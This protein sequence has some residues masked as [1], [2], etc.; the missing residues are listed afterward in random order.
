VRLYGNDGGSVALSTAPDNAGACG[1]FVSQAAP[2][3]VAGVPANTYD[4]TLA[5]AVSARCL[6]ITYTSCCLWVNAFELLAYAATTP[7]G[8]QWSV[9]GKLGNAITVS[10]AWP[11]VTVK[12]SASLK[13]GANLALEAWVKPRANVAGT[14]RLVG[15]GAAATQ[16][17]DLLR[18]PDGDL[19]WQIDGAGGSGDC[20]NNLGPTDPLN[21][22]VGK[23]THVAGTFNGVT[24]KVYVNGVMR[25]Q[26]TFVDTPLTSTDDLAIGAGFD[27]SID[28]VAIFNSPLSDAIIAD[29]YLRGM[30][31]DAAGAH[32]VDDTGAL[33]TT[34]GRAAAALSFDAIDDY[35][36][37]PDA[38]DLSFTSTSSVFTLSASIKPS[39]VVGASAIIGKYSTDAGSGSEYY[40][41][42]SGDQLQLF[43][44]ADGVPGGEYYEV[45]TDA[46]LTTGT[47]AD[48]SVVI[49]MQAASVSFYKD[50]VLLNDITVGAFPTA[51][52]DTAQPLMIGGRLCAGGVVCDPF[53]GSIDEV[54]VLDGACV[55]IAG[56]AAGLVVSGVPASVTAGTAASVTVRAVTCTLATVTSYTGTMT[57]SSTDPYPAAFAP[58]SY[59]FTGVDAGSKVFTNGVTLK[60]AGT[61]SVT[62]TDAGLG[63]GGTQA[64]IVVVA[65][66]AANLLVSSGTP[67]SGTV[68]TALGLPLVVRVTDTYGNAIAGRA[69]TWATS[70]GGGGV[71]PSSS[72]TNAS[73]LATADA[74]LGTVSG[75][76]NN[77]WTATSGALTPVS[78]TATANPGAAANLAVSS[79]SPQSGTVGT[80]LGLPLAVRVTD[81]YGNVVPG[82]TVSWTTTAGG[83][84]V[85]P[86]TSNTD[87][88]GIATASATLG[89]VSGTGNNTWTATLGVLTPATFTATANPGAAANL[90]VYSGSPQSGTVGTALGLPLAVR[91]IDSYGNP[92][93][94]LT[95]TWT[96]TLGGGSVAPATSDTNASGI[97]EAGATLGTVS[98]TSNNQWTATRVGLAGSPATFT[99]T[100]TAGAA[101]SIAA[102]LGVGQSG[103]VGTALSQALAVIVKDTYGNAV[104]GVL[105]GWATAAGGGGI[106]PASST[107]SAGGV[108]TASATLGT[109][110]GTNNNQWTATKTGLAGSPVTFT[111]TANA[112]AAVA[113]ALGGIGGA[114]VAGALHTVTVTALDQFGNTAAGYLGTVQWSS[115][116]GAAVLPFDLTFGG[117][118]FGV[119]VFTDAVVLKTAATQSVTVTDTVNGLLT[120]SILGIL[121]S[122]EAASKLSVTGITA[123]TAGVA[124]TV[125]VT[126]R[127]PF[128]NV[129]KGYLGTVAFGSDDP[130]PAS[131]PGNTTF[132]ALDQGTRTFTNGVTFKTSGT[133]T[134]TATDVP[135]SSITGLQSG[136]VVSPAARDHV[137]ISGIASPQVG[138]NV[139]YGLQVVDSFGNITP[140]VTTLLADI[141]TTNSALIA[142]TTLLGGSTGGTSTTGSTDGQG[143][144]QVT[145]RDDVTE[146]V[147]LCV[148]SPSFVAV[149]C[150]PLTFIPRAADHLL[151]T[152]AVTSLVVGTS[153]TVAVQLVD[154]FDNGVAQAVAATLAVSGSARFGG[155][156]NT[157]SIT[158]AAGTGQTSTQVT[159]TV[160]GSVSVSVTSTDKGGGVPLAGVS[161]AAGIVFTAAAVHHAVLTTVP[162]TTAGASF[163]VNIHA[164]DQYGNSTVGESE[165][166]LTTNA[167]SGGSPLVVATAGTW[168]APAGSMICGKT[169]ASDGVGTLSITDT[170]AE[171]IGLV[172]TSWVGS[173]TPVSQSA[174]VAVVPAAADHLV[175]APTDG[176]APTCGTELVGMQL[177]DVYGNAVASP[178]FVG[179]AVTAN[180]AALHPKVAATSVNAAVNVVS[181]SGSLSPGGAGDATVTLDGVDT[182]TL[183]WTLPGL[184]GPPTGTVAVVFDTGAP[185]AAKSLFV[186]SPPS[187]AKIDAWSGEATLTVTPKDACGANLGPGYDVDLTATFGLLSDA[188]PAGDGK[189]RALDNGDGTYTSTFRTDG[190][191]CPAVPATLSVVV[192][193]PATMVPVALQTTVSLSSACEPVSPASVVTPATASLEACAAGL[194]HA[195]GITHDAGAFTTVS[196]TPV[197]L[198]GK[199][200]GPN[201]SVHINADGVLL[202]EQGVTSRIDP[203]TLATTYDIEV[204]S[205]RCVKA[206][207]SREVVVSVN[208]VEM[209]TRAKIAFNCPP[210]ASTL[211]RFLA[212]PAIVPADLISAAEVVVT[213]RDTCGNPAFARPTTLRIVD[214]AAYARVEPATPVDTADKLGTPDDATAVFKVRSDR[215][216]I[217]AAEATVTGTLATSPKGLLTFAM[218]ESTVVMSPSRGCG[219]AAASGG[220]PAGVWLL[221]LWAVVIGLARRA[222]R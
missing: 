198:N 183:R 149:A 21:I 79:G 68:G 24:M 95:I 217:T 178:A 56:Q 77:Q 30:A 163:T 71:T 155:G 88:S 184:S 129:A 173:I 109:V 118:D 134:V 34:P 170:R 164:V 171:T 153:V 66:A 185:D 145:L 17:Y 156:S 165:V 111:A 105:V 67:Q 100:A 131:L 27:G 180:L 2:I 62:V 49:D 65:A 94:G 166:C 113:L 168:G 190:A 142:T 124:R 3:K 16:N 127:D 35:V 59:T 179:L 15:K 222:R 128:D 154:L 91:V 152:P 144:G 43:L 13:L 48:V 70:A 25:K 31:T 78:F 60:T 212:R 150:L 199:P 172:G 81:T 181:T 214:L 32:V 93:P 218:E 84:S 141:G 108:A 189:S 6:K 148:S 58:S 45:T 200:L 193:D 41:R 4:W 107:T 5:P 74:T 63:I 75:T 23:W 177:V 10:P 57:F 89:T 211:M 167:G 61:Q 219:C 51:L 22:P 160:V 132:T 69:I 205:N 86:S 83:G 87:A 103:T 197:D 40:L 196:V 192:T 73:G 53:A 117:S 133:R 33:S 116:D 215:A 157:T 136:I 80:A 19:L 125:V 151:L 158:T 52:V 146:G 213:A 101:S 209:T 42:R 216:G 139:P 206:P 143:A 98:G 175:M 99:A 72:T 120:A 121:V 76:S 38:A 46:A 106:A 39:A 186:S 11:G 12:D 169:R 123:T 220:P 64:G 126:A 221:G 44:D 29:H 50:G 147:T 114:T 9:A 110:A 90:A 191:D 54:A 203:V 119:H 140:T 1:A 26:C 162:S 18:D 47:W 161:L 102:S 182:L 55:S 187:G 188:S 85:T 96:T 176:V 82:A 115:S 130:Y 137:V 112:D 210:V 207:D 122:P 36:Q 201:Q 138:G 20:S 7:T 202:I 195:D 159:S 194:I 28:E 8:A 174:T 97:A 208:A 37:T 104:P 135:T 14:V 204:G 92:V